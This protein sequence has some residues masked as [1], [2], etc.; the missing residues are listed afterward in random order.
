[1][2]IGFIGSG[3]IGRGACEN[4]VKKGHDVAV[5]DVSA[6]A[7]E[8]FRGK[9][10]LV[11]NPADLFERSEVVLLSLPSSVQVEAMCDTFLSC[12]VKDKI[13]IDL[14]TSYPLSTKAARSI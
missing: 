14:S 7:M 10:E 13:V 2:K 5:Y 6:D 9:A 8:Y 1:M 3:R 12:G 11:S 4:F